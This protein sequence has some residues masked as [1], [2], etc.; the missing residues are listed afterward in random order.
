[1]C[2]AATSPHGHLAGVRLAAPRPA[3]R[4]GGPSFD[5]LWLT[6][7]ARSHR[8]GDRQSAC[9][10]RSSVR[11]D[12]LSY[13]AS[14]YKVSFGNRT[15]VLLQSQYPAWRSLT[16]VSG[17]EGIPHRADGSYVD[18][19]EFFGNDVM[20]AILYRRHDPES[21]D[22]YNSQSDQSGYGR[23]HRQRIHVINIVTLPTSGGRFRTPL[24]NLRHARKYGIGGGNVNI[25]DGDRRRISVIGL[26]DNISRQNFSFGHLGTTDGSSKSSS[27]NNFMVAQQTASRPCRPS[28]S[29]TA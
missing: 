20:S 4:H 15:P 10:A 25:F 11:G 19:R 23:R 1:M 22:I 13:R 24:R 8:P 21:I 12:T 16:A 5:S 27:N 7:R 3:G 29:I 17:T 18:G 14:A 28:A 2:R 6:P 9:A 26:A